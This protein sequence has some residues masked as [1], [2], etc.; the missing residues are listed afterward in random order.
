MRGEGGQIGVGRHRHDDGTG[1]DLVM[2]FIERVDDLVG[3]HRNDDDAG[4]LSRCAGCVRRDHT[5]ALGEMFGVGRCAGGGMDGA[6]FDPEPHQTLE[7]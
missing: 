7:Q 1:L 5:E 6:G 2:D 3:T 4:R